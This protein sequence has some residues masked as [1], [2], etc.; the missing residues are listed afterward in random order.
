MA[1][2]TEKQ[3]PECG[4]K[5]RFPNNVGGIVM[6]CP[7][8]GKKFGSDFKL[9]GVGSSPHT[10]LAQKIFE[11]PSTHLERLYRLFLKR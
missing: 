10:G 4:Q 3:C 9:G 1:D 8:C 5:L 6:A 11:M 2:Y 7:T